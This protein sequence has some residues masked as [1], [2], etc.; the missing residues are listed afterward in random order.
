VHADNI[1]ILYA[2][3]EGGKV[4][5]SEE[6]VDLSSETVI[7]QGSTATASEGYKFI[8]WMDENAQIVSSDA[9]FVPANLTQNKTYTAN[10]EKDE[11]KVQKLISASVV[12]Y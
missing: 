4:S 8:N 6:M 11:V 9:Y 10:F 5:L 7:F 1:T 12:T 2:A 3:G